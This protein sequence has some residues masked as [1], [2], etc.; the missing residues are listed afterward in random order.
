[1]PR[2]SLLLDQCQL[3]GWGL[4]SCL[5]GTPWRELLGWWDVG[6]ASS[7]RVKAG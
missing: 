5:S 6:W 7:F 2:A 4:R 1:M 3:V